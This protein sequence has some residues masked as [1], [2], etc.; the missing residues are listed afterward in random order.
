MYDLGEIV[1]NPTSAK[2]FILKNKVLIDAVSKTIHGLERY[3]NGDM[4]IYEG[5]NLRR[6][7]LSKDINH[8][9]Q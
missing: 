6:F 5:E 8:P 4:N 7:C 1:L 3:G 2:A 9:K